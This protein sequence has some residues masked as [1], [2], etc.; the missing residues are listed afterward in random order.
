M[1]IANADY[2]LSSGPAGRRM[3]VRWAYRTAVRIALSYCLPCVF[4]ARRSRKIRIRYPCHTL[5]L[6][7]EL[8]LLSRIDSRIGKRE[9]KSAVVPA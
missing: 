1:E 3:V 5:T 8:I 2:R 4:S 9:R 6:V 7:E